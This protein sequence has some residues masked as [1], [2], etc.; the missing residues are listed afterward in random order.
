MAYPK[1]KIYNWDS[2][3][4]MLDI[5]TVAMIF[6]VTEETIKKWCK[7]GELKPFKIGNTVRFDKYY[8]KN[9]CQNVG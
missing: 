8:I 9:I 3:P 7:N 4:V 5:N 6:D 1:N 2:L